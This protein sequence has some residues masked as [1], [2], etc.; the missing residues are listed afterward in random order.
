MTFIDSYW[1]T[2]IKKHQDIC[3]TTMSLWILRL[4]SSRFHYNSINARISVYHC[5]AFGISS[6]V[7]EETRNTEGHHTTQ[8]I[9][10]Q[11]AP[12][13]THQGIWICFP[14]CTQWERLEG[15]R[16]N[17]PLHLPSIRTHSSRK[18][19][20]SPIETLLS[21][22]ELSIPKKE[23]SKSCSFNAQ[24][25]LFRVWNKAEWELDLDYASGSS[26]KSR[27]PTIHPV[28]SNSKVESPLSN[29]SPQK[30]VLDFALENDLWGKNDKRNTKQQLLLFS[31]D[32]LP[33]NTSVAI[34][35]PM[36]AAMG[37]R[38]TVGER[39]GLGAGRELPKL[40]AVSFSCLV[41]Q[42]N[43]RKKPQWEKRLQRIC[44]K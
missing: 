5:D 38:T 27:F 20:E 37:A 34:S 44:K 1:H 24:M 12:R 21:S 15:L 41:H 26:S 10:F 8:E 43:H 30:S 14:R 25:K 11:Q 7:C 32:S 22:F 40:V 33:C 13:R 39:M 18:V 42:D 36:G 17:Q 23:R 28:S 3:Y 16:L 2:N 9:E 31:A 19:G 35:I 6:S 4:S 29:F